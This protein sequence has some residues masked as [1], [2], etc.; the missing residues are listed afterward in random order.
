MASRTLPASAVEIGMRGHEG[1]RFRGRRLAKAVDIVMAVAFGMGD[2]DERAEREIL[3]HGEAGLAG[4][5]LA[6]SRKTSR[7]PALHFAARVALTI[8]L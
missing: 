8:D 5:V 2:A 7:R 1:L 6:A 4:Q 3:L